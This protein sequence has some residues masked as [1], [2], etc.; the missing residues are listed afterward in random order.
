MKLDKETLVKH[1]FWLLLG[2]SGVLT[3]AALVL[4]F[5]GP[6]AK[7]AKA[8]T[9]FQKN[10][11]NLGPKNA[12]TKDPKNDSFLKPW[13]KRRD[14]FAEHKNIV[15]KQAWDTQ[16]DIMTWPRDLA[17]LEKGHFG[18]NIPDNERLSYKETYY[19]KQF[20]P[21]A[22]FAPE[23]GRGVYFPVS[24]NK[25]K[26]FG[27]HVWDKTKP[28]PSVEECWMAQEDIWV[29]REILKVLQHALR[30]MG[31]FKP[32]REP[33]WTQAVP[34]AAG[35]ALDV[36]VHNDPR[37]R[38]F[39][40][41]S[42]VRLESSTLLSQKLLLMTGDVYTGYVRLVSNAE[43]PQEQ[44]Q[45]LQELRAQYKVGEDFSNARL[46]TLP[47]GTLPI[48]GKKQKYL[49]G[50]KKSLLFRSHNWE[51]NLLLEAKPNTVD[52]LQISAHSTIKNISPARRA[53]SLNN[54][55]RPFRL[56]FLQGNGDGSL[57]R[58]TGELLRW[59]EGSEFKESFTPNI[60]F[61]KDFDLEEDFDPVTSPIKVLEEL[62]VGRGALYNRF[63]V[64]GFEMQKGRLAPK[65]KTDAENPEGQGGGPTGPQYGSSGG[66]GPGGGGPGGPGG[67]PGGP[68]AAS[69]GPD[70]M[71]MGPRGQAALSE[72]PTPNGFNRFRYVLS[73][74]IEPVRRIPVAFTI[75][76]D[77]AFR[78]EVLSA[79][80]NSRL[81][82]QTTWVY[83]AHRG[84][85][86]PV[87]GTGVVPGF[88]PPDRYRMPEGYRPSGPGGPG[89]PV[90]PPDMG[91]D[92]RRP[93][94]PPPPG[95]VGAPRGTG[96][97]PD[98]RSGGR[99]PVS[100]PPPPPGGVGGTEP[101]PPT[102]SAAVANS[103]L[104][105]LT[106][107]GIAALFERYPPKQKPTEGDNPAAPK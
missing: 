84:D 57:I 14:K 70:G 98:R 24:F 51:V 17:R 95:G 30:A 45:R 1:Q 80:A 41:F 102:D 43:L 68:G 27:R 35:P 62:K 73:P 53:L 64:G 104:I 34:A 79:V 99:P 18:D 2:L 105:E 50:I 19:E 63:V 83:W 100:P 31:Q 60:D 76:V 67:G 106:V 5:L 48:P 72:D 42:G 89:G 66:G 40:E 101:T 38:L 49:A 37:A 94:T 59:G 33:L 81:R 47:R 87:T 82:I 86:K 88:V 28:V 103:N 61:N 74:E 92:G 96:V 13:N 46:E 58:L 6:R 36:L 97:P 10:K 25:D 55:G 8:R 85:Y 21:E 54:A 75:V 15:W 3:L 26:I 93:V 9:D 11:D 32:V 56:R 91:S 23:A 107:H 16:S 69:P 7:A 65:P 78:N 29:R 22:F 71:K 39:K 44:A 12:V 90:V 4:L 52:E 20:T 77:Q